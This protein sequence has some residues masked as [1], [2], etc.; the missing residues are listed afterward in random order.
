MA[1]KQNEC[2]VGCCGAKELASESMYVRCRALQTSCSTLAAFASSAMATSGMDDI[3]RNCD[4]G[5]RNGL[6]RSIGWPRLLAIDNAIESMIG[7]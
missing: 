2:C 7:C 1:V 5:F 6:T 4:D 3:G